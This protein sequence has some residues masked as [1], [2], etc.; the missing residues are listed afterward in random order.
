MRFYLSLIQTK[1][2]YMNITLKI[3]EL[4][5]ISTIAYSA[6]LFIYL[7]KHKPWAKKIAD[8]L[9]EAKNQSLALTIIFSFFLILFCLSINF[10][11][12]SANIQ[13]TILLLVLQILELVPFFFLGLAFCKN[14][15]FEP[16]KSSLLWKKKQSFS[17][18]LQNYAIILLAAIATATIAIG[19]EQL[20]TKLIIKLPQS[21]SFQDPFSN[22]FGHR[23][24]IFTIFLLLVP[25]IIAEEGIFRLGILSAVY[26]ISKNKHIAAITSATLFSLFHLLPS[27]PISAYIWSAP[28]VHF[29]GLILAGMLYGYIFLWKR[30]EIVVIFH[31]MIVFVPL[32]IL[33]L[34]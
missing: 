27:H 3:V 24:S 10:R 14:I 7:S 9:S 31:I 11:F 2:L 17:F 6:I 26:S 32:V 15:H 18:L 34:S 16:L 12:A 8:N 20:I 22:I 1:I 28:I 33:R 23:L 25:S 21:S 5:I 30:F 29:S 4:I 19:L 13:I